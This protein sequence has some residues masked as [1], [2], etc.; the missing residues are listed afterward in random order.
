MLK[1][2]KVLFFTALIVLGIFLL[3]INTS[4]STNSPDGAIRRQLFHV[5][6]LQSFTC[7]ITK[8]DF[9]DKIYGQQYIIDGFVDPLTQGEISFAY[10]KKNTIGEYYWTGGGTGP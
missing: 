9:F 8:T 7:T 3:A 10:V 1:A 5:N 2:K 6:P 4:Y